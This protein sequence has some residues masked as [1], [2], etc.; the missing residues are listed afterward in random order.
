MAGMR[1][2]G[3]MHSENKNEGSEAIVSVFCSAVLVAL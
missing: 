3:P 1:S 2:T